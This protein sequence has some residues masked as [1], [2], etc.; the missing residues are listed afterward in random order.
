VDHV[1]VYL[2]GDQRQATLLPGQPSGPVGDGGRGSHDPRARYEP[3]VSL[4]VGPL[5]GYGQIGPR[6]P[7]GADKTIYVPAMRTAVRGYR[8][9]VNENTRRHDQSG[10]FRVELAYIT[11]PESGP[12]AGT[13]VSPVRS[14]RTPSAPSPRPRGRACPTLESWS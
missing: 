1:R 9:R 3:P 14:E 11:G 10:P 5:A 4:L 12:Q 7:E 6:R 13:P 2:L 8:G